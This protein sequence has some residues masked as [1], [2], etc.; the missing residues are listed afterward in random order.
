MTQC[1]IVVDEG[2]DTAQY[3]TN[4]PPAYKS[5]P[6]PALVEGEQ[7]G[8]LVFCVFVPTNG[9]Q[10]GQMMQVPFARIISVS[11]KT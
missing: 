3:H 4:D 2:A 5:V 1:T 9:Y 10:K 8:R 11:E 7:D 6:I